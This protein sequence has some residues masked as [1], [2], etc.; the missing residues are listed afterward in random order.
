MRRALWLF[1]ASTLALVGGVVYLI[2]R[3]DPPAF[4]I[5]HTQPFFLE[6]VSKPF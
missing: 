1:I 4:V 5:D 2:V 3:D 6:T